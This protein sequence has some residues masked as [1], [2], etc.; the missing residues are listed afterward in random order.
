[1]TAPF[2]YTKIFL[3]FA[4]AGDYF[5]NKDVEIVGNPIRNSLFEQAKSLELSGQDPKAEAMKGFG[6]DPSEPSILVLGG[7]QGAESINNFILENLE[8]LIR[9]FQI[10][11]QVGERNYGNYKKEYEFMAKDWSEAEKNRY[12]FQAFFGKDMADAL[13]SAD[14]VIARASSGSIFELAAFGKPAILVP[15][16]ESAQD[17]QKSNAYLYAE[18]GAAIVIEEENL[19]GN[20]VI[21][22]LKEIILNPERRQKMAESAQ[23]FYR[24]DSAVIIAKYLLTYVR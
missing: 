10:L 22:K 8:L 17:H 5:N 20:L 13:V 18:T 21:N 2:N 12:R 4:S 16:P 24:P 19:L 11:H 15:L 1:M 9:D 14:A 3:A 23:S 7:S 6:L